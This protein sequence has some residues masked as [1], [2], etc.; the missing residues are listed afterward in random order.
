[1][2]QNTIQTDRPR[3]TIWHVHIACWIS[4]VTNT[5]LEYVTVI[6]F[7]L[8]HWLHERKSVIHYMYMACLVTYNLD[9]HQSSKGC[10]LFCKI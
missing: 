5:Y 9:E 1:M 3:M 10:I 2:W 4:M 7:P 8:Q 6:A